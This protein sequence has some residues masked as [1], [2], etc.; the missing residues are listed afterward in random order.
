MK[1]SKV[2][3]TYIKLS[4]LFFLFLTACIIGLAVFLP[5]LIDI[6]DYRDNIMATL[7]Q[8][9]HRKVTFGT[10]VFSMYFGPSFIFETV[11]IKEPDNSNDFIKAKR[12]TVRLALLPLLEKKVVLRELVLEGAGVNLVRNSDGKLNIDDLLKPQPG[13]PPVSLKKIRIKDSTLQ[14]YDMAIQKGGFRDRVDNLTLSLDNFL[15]GRKG[16][17]KISCGLPKATGSAAKISLS[18]TAR[19]PA[20]T[21]SL[22]ETEINANADVKQIEIGRFWPYYGRFIPFGNPGGRLDLAGNFKGKLREFN[23]KGKIRLDGVAVTWP[24]IFHHVVNPRSAQLDYEFKLAGN[25]IDMPALQFSAEGFK[26]KGSCQLKDINSKDLYIAAKGTTTPFKLEELRQWIPYGIIAKD[27][28]DYI[29]NHITAGTY[30]L[31]TGSLTGRV[32]QI[33]HM[34]K[35]TNYNVLHI[36]G[37]VENSVV[38]YGRKVPAFNSIRGGLE[39]L[40]KDFILNRMTG[41]FGSSPFKMDGRITDYPL[42]VAC[43]YPFQ[44]EITP[45]A[46]EIAWLAKIAGATKLEYGGNSTLTLTGNGPIP[47]YRLNGDWELKQAAYSFPGA[48]HKPAGTANHLSFCTL[49]GPNETR[50]T[51]LTYQ[52]PP[53]VLSASALLKYGDRPH[54]GFELQTN[55]FLL[56][57]SLPIFSSWRPYHL[58]GQVQAHIFG[59]G[60][61][62]DFTAMDYS[63][64]ISLGSFS[65]QPG[66]NLKPVSNIN[67]NINFKGN[68]LET[69]KISVYYGNSLIRAKGRINNFKKREAEITLF[70]PQFFLR[71][72]NFSNA[73]PDASIRRMHAALLVQ[74]NRYTIHKF[75]GLLNSSNFS[76]S[77]SYTSGGSP[78]ANLTVNSSHLDIGDLLFLGTLREQEGNGQNTPKLNLKL[79]LNVEAGNYDK[80]QF[81]KLSAQLNQE[82]GILYLQGLEAAL[83]GG[84]VS[85]KGRVA[86]SGANVNR[87]DLS[88]NMERINA[89]L[90]FQAL[91]ITKE[92]KGTLNLQ[93]DLTARGA[94]W[95]DVRKSAL[96]NLRLR[97]TDGS[98][99]KFNV[100]SKVFSILNVSQLL[101][102]QLPDMVSG[103]M[104]YNEIKGSIAVKDGIASSQDLFIAGNAIN[105]S[106]VGN[107]DIVKEDLDLTIGV[108]PLQT[109]DKIVNHIPVVGWLL[110]G[111]GKSVVTAYFEAK[112]KWSDPKVSAIPVK[113]MAKGVFNIF[114]RVF[115]LPVRLFTDT[116]EVILGK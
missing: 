76:I 20:G 28:A 70:S 39:M 93:G 77:G 71:D 110:T 65:F 22:L 104:P 113:S 21:T 23:S 33:I 92:V 42:N 67:G 40:G 34:E 44:M 46:P 25:T 108:Q 41:K 63:G 51:S 35:G 19:L 30:R 36:K 56:S 115:E 24:T 69:S 94:T 2:K 84:S 10:G 64:A 107:A 79:K 97:L 86:P 13:T 57:D 12:V 72:A 88:F 98:L 68:S 66:E 14:W 103:G 102:F 106:I 55:Q 47:A 27:V 89:E 80:L 18:G 100:L 52:L 16:S 74:D 78:E 90:F 95:L 82:S 111:K 45:H 96:G 101:K 62:E 114:R 5:R 61:P 43:N 109:V 60:N 54:L 105:M 116:G 7:Q 49:L 6:N 26:I 83:C 17:F 99:R 91:D 15:R 87:Y 3:R 58:Q 4:G 73:K 85:V 11:T 112:G 38:S 31:E 48:V 81:A 75:S 1:L 9:L 37:T 32:S 53:L 29:E 8:S 50:L 59:N